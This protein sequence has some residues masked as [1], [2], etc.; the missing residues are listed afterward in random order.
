[1]VTRWYRAPEVNLSAD[2]GS[3]IDL[4][5]AG[6]IFA[7]LLG[8]QKENFSAFSDRQILFPGAS[9]AFLSPLDEGD[10][11]E[12]QLN[13]IFNVIG[14]PEPD[15]IVRICTNPSSATQ[16]YVAALLEEAQPGVVCC[17]LCVVCVVC[18]VLCIV[19]CVLCVMCTY[20]VSFFFVNLCSH[21]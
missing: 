16:A 12:E 9:S 3:G 15:E 2:Y 7:E 14:T 18:V 21:R 17:V 19:C 10:D 5:S 4:W 20:L 6:C 1:V 11:K 13:I 8:M